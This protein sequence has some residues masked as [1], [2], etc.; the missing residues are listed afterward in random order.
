MLLLCLLLRMNCLNCAGLFSEDDCG[1]IQHTC[2]VYTELEVNV[3]DGDSLRPPTPNTPLPGS[4]PN[5]CPNPHA[6]EV[7]TLI[8]AFSSHHLDQATSAATERHF[9]QILL[10]FYSCHW[11]FSFPPLV[12]HAG[13]WTLWK[14]NHH[15]V[16]LSHLRCTPDSFHLADFT[17][18]RERLHLLWCV[19]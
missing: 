8:T 11:S 12:I 15:G 2:T 3:T 17:E 16:Y 5:P 13:C 19:F 7:N 18:C 9:N 4:P 6:C 14:L 1:V 10:Q